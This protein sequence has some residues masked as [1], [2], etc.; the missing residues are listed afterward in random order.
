M[1]RKFYAEYDAPETDVIVI[2]VEGVLCA[3]GDDGEGGTAGGDAGG[4]GGIEW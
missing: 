4:E 2:D 3:S 1:E